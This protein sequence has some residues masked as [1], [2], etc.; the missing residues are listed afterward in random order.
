MTRGVRLLVLA[1]AASQA[2]A[3]PSEVVVPTQRLPLG[4]SH[5]RHLA[6]GL[7]CTRCHPGATTSTRP[8]DRLI[9]GKSVCLTCHGEG[10]RAPLPC[11][12]CHPGFDGERAGQRPE[13]LVLPPARLRFPHRRHADAGVACADCHADVDATDLATRA[14]LPRERDCVGCHAERDVSTRCRTCH[15]TGPDGLLRTSFSAELPAPEARPEARSGPPL[16]PQGR[17]PS[18]ASRAGRP[19]GSAGSAR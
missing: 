15:P 13:P 5:Q 12:G 10:Q 18:V 1:A 16:R 9:H 6:G 14:H 7:R 19:W 3:G 2:A 17:C 11:D 8:E 4:F